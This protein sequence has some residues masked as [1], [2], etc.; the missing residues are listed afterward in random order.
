MPTATMLG[1]G[2]VLIAQRP[3]KKMM[4]V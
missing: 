4:T 2:A 1:G 3:M